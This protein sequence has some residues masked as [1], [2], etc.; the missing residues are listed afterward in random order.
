M[1][2]IIKAADLFC[3]AGG[4]S[5]GAEQ[6]GAA[7]VVCAVDHW[8]TA[9]ETHSANFPHTKHINSRLDQ[10]NPGECPKIDLLFA[11]PECTHHSR[12]R[13]G[14]PTSDQQRSGSW[15]IMRWV[16]FHRPSWIVIENVAELRQWG[17][18][19]DNGQPLK[20]HVGKFFDAWLLAI[21]AAGYKVDHR[22]L[23]AADYGA[24]T[25]R[26]RLFVVARKGN[27]SPVWPDPTHAARVGGELPG[28]G[29]QRWRSAAEIID[30][31]IPCKSVF[32]RKHPLKDNTL[33]RIEAGLRR[34]VE[35]FVVQLRNNMTA[36]AVHDPLA[37]IT[38]GGTHHGVAVPFQYQLIGLGAGRSKSIGEPLP[39]MVASRE[40]HG[41]AVP[42]VM[43]SHAGGAARGVGE[44]V[45]TVTARGGANF[46]VPFLTPNFGEREGQGP[47]THA[48]GNALPAVTSHGAGQL[49]V[50]F[51]SAFHN[52]A[53]SN[54]RNYPTGNVLPTQDT[55]NRYGLAVPFLQQLTHGGRNLDIAAPMRTITTAH[56]GETAIAVPFVVTY[57]ANGRAYSVADP[58]CTISTRDRCGMACAIIEPCPSIEPRTEGERK[59]LATMIELGVADVGFR[60]LVNSEL[61][62]AQGFPASYIY[63]GNKGEVTKQ[64]GNSVSPNVADAITRAIAA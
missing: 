9:V 36:G 2:R 6:S 10:V 34:F 11:S 26:T 48:I 57:Y 38:A 5:Q 29:M 35:P 1:S 32:L 24:A 51:L 60:M 46:A 4:T 43:S 13:G 15:D 64:I 30:W 8:Q 19:G 37:T 17:P 21:E 18:I 16:E 42:F 49:A 56:R 59:L 28:M 12:A 23:N 54:N 22:L 20:K 55:S 58:L 14:R 7:R 25:S 41:V 52:G 50:P 53:D 47:R 33:L 45:P 31:S 40:N 3:G 63:T 44:P 39:T 27:R 61:S 62:L